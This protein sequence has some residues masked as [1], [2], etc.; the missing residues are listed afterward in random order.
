MSSL[1]FISSPL[2]FLIATSLILRG[3]DD[4]STLVFISKSRAISEQYVSV[5]NSFSGVFSRVI[6]LSM[7]AGVSV[8]RH[9][10][11]AI[12]ELKKLVASSEFSA[13]YTGNDR[14]VEFQYTMHRLRQTNKNIKAAYID[15]GA[16]SYLGHKY[17]G[18]LAHNRLDPVLKKVFTG[19]WWKQAETTGSSSWIST[20]YLAFPE[21][22]HS[23]LREKQILPVNT[24]AFSG[25][26]FRQISS[27]VLAAY[28]DLDLEQL[29]RI[30]CLVCLPGESA[31]L[32][33]PSM[34]KAFSDTVSKVGDTKPTAIK[35]HPRS[36]N[37]DLVKEYFPDY[38][39][40]PKNVGM[41]FLLSELNQQC[42]ILGDIS[43]TLLT[44]RW[45]LPDAKIRAVEHRGTSSELVELFARLDIDLVKSQF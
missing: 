5:A 25:D 43:S 37:I 23:L 24:D 17:M 18:K 45:I 20:A 26:I 2:H 19:W 11:L 40:L 1:Y 15:D 32:K 10:K 42:T 28:S 38:V 27:A 31:Y 16:I 22:A 35:M 13:V 21:L 39:L 9:R 30:E 7:P 41:E 33:N 44:A 6:D 29:K 34:L 4:Q 14:R 8:Y 36:K 12:N 3:E